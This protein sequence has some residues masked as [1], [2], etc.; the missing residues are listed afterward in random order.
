M[1]PG[2]AREVLAAAPLLVLMVALGVVPSVVL[3]VVHATTR[4]LLP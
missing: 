2:S 4:A 3:D 1:T